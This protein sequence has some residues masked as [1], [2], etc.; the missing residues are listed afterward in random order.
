VGGTP[1]PRRRSAWTTRCGAV[2]DGEGRTT[3]PDLSMSVGPPSTH[4]RTWWAWQCDCRQ[5]GCA[6]RER[7]GLGECVPVALGGG[8]GVVLPDLVDG[9]GFRQ[10]SPWLR[11]PALGV[12][13]LRRVGVPVGQQPVP[14]LPHRQR[15][16]LLELHQRPLGVCPLL[17]VEGFG[18]ATRWISVTCSTVIDPPASA[19][20]VNGNGVLACATRAFA[21]RVDSRSVPARK[22]AVSRYPLPA[23][24]PRPSASE[25]NVNI[26][27]YP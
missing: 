12:L 26:R 1:V 22:V 25:T 21:S 17:R 18:C 5:V 20:P 4:S 27:P 11:Q 15:R 10:P 8:A 16:R 23:A 3:A 19:T 24:N 13:R 14:G 2:A 6:G 9:A 7:D